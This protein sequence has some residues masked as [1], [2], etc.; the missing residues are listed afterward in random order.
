MIFN[1]H[2]G[3]LWKNEKNQNH[4]MP[5][6]TEKKYTKHVPVAEEQGNVRCCCRG[7]IFCTEKHV[8]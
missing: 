1:M 7:F 3:A 2:A 8:F 4:T 5:Q 6:I